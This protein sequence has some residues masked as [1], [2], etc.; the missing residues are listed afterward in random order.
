MGME[1]RHTKASVRLARRMACLAGAGLAACSAG[2][3]EGLDISGRPVDE[4]GDV[5][6]VA[7]L[8]SIQANVFDP[9][10]VICHSGAAAPLGLRLDEANSFTNLVGVPS[11]QDSGVLRVAPGNP[12]QS[13]LIRKIE[14]TAS[15]GERMPLGGAPLPQATIDVVRQWISDGAPPGNAGPADLPPTVVSLTPLPASSGA[16]FP[17]E[18]VAGFD[19]EIDASTVNALTFRLQRAGG[20]G[21][22]D[23]ADDVDVVASAVALSPANPRL[24]IMN[25]EGVAAIADRYRVTLSG[26]GASVILSIGGKALD[27][28]FTGT[29]P[30]GDSN[31]GGDFVAEF[32]VQGVQATLVSIQQNVFT[33]T[34]AVAGCHTGPT[35]PNLPAGMD[36]STESA[37]FASLVNVAS[38]QQPGILRVAPNDADGS[39]LV[40]KLEGTAASGM[41]MP[42]GGGALDPPVIEAIRAWIDAGANQ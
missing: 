31:E 12:G 8:S 11:R 22:F 18:I 38:L 7:T 29:F 10:C 30:S 35:G 17:T 23:D 41:R 39:Y 24:A 27:G 1:N 40:Q 26:S 42:L 2:S 4:G 37:S 5:P 15:E 36:L 28:E 6:L 25:L 13:Y 16:E 21:Q 33:P 19:Q 3:G 32:E 34:C 9:F 14:G 20:D